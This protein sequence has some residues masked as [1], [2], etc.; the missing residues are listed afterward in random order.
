MCQVSHVSIDS[1]SRGFH[2]AV[3]SWWLADMGLDNMKR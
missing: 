1:K 2:P 3:L